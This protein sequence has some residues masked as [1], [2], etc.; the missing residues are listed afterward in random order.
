MYAHL[1]IDDILRKAAQIL[2]VSPANTGEVLDY[3][4]LPIYVTDANGLLT[5]F[6]RACMPFTGRT[7]KIGIDRWCV[8]WELYTADGHRLPHDQCPMAIAIRER[9][10]VRGAHAVALRPDGTTISFQPRPTPLY[11]RRG[12][13]MGAINALVADPRD[14]PE[15]A[16]RAELARCCRRAQTATDV[17][18]ILALQDYARQ[19]EAGLL[20]SRVGKAT[21]AGRSETVSNAL[22][23]DCGE[24]IFDLCVWV[25]LI[26]GEVLAPAGAPAAYV[27]FLQSG[28]ASLRLG[29]GSRTACVGMFGREGMSGHEMISGEPCTPYTVAMETNGSAL[30]MSVTDLR[31][32]LEATPVLRTRIAQ[33]AQSLFD[34]VAMT[35]FVNICGDLDARLAHWLALVADRAGPELRLTHGT[36][37][38]ALGVR[39]ASITQAIHRLEGEKA[40]RSTRARLLV[41]NRAKLRDIAGRPFSAGGALSTKTEDRTY[42]DEQPAS[43]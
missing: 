18:T 27:H 30:R 25:P 11:D 31:Q 10:S 22:L 12:N 43:T 17:R 8:T 29:R 34:Q 2:E 16:L 4:T 15:S 42:R 35:S 24:P 39:R 28:F 13:F 32:I 21:A 20:S 9:R 40:V 1:D 38:S 3:L 33:F 5:H 36:L 26:A 7:P 37:A 23:A 14:K 19:C 6:N 41:T